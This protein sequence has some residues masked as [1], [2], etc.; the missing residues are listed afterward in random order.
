[1]QNSKVD[2]T[3][4]KGVG[5]VTAEKLAE[6]GFATVE[7]IAVAPARLIAEI[8]GIAEERAAEITRAA[9]EI[10]GLKFMTAE[11]YFEAREQVAYV[12]TGC[13]ALD[14]LL[15]GG[16][17]T[18]AVTEL[19]GEF[20]TGKTQLCHQLCVTVQLPREEGGL[21]AGAVY[22]DTEGTFRPERIVQMASRFNLE[23]R[24]A[25]RN[26]VYARAY[27]T[28]HQM[29]LVDE[30]QQ[31]IVEKNLRLLIVDSLVSHF[32]AEY[33]GR[34]LLLARQQKLNRH[35]HQLL[36]LADLYNVAVIVTNQVIANPDTIYGNPLVPAGGN[37]VAHGCTYRIWI[38]R[39]QGNKRIARIFDSP[40][41]PE[42]EAV[43]TITE[44][45]IEDI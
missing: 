43:F 38:R 7:K 36:K 16:V 17:E 32:R 8:L 31:F 39:S 23:P 6:A 30:A 42:A 33:P 25:L 24:K 10:I 21:E 9:R 20:G 19:V 29:L 11:E 34:E 37:I 13:R 45:G 12:T 44:Q 15:G 41:H 18:G 35:V 2:L 27:N 22:I 5:P 4:I 14:D 40:K 26:I 1:M 3:R 28:D